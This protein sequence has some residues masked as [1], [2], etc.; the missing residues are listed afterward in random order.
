MMAVHLQLAEAGKQQLLNGRYGDALDRFRSALKLGVEQGAPAVF[1]HHYTD[2]VLDCLEAA[3]DQEQALALTERALDEQR[4][5]DLVLGRAV[6]AGLKQR[7]VLLLY[8]LGRVE[9]GDEA[10]ESMAELSGPIPDA[11]RQARRRRLNIDRRWVDNLRRR[12]LPSAVQ[13][14]QLRRDDATHGETLFRKEFAHG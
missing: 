11:I 13:P 8:S 1:L 14:D 2:C 3:G 10:L 7:R 12:H 6:Q 4:P 5:G 9:D